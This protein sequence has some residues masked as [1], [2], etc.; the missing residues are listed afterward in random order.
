M[1]REA[2][3]ILYDL[4]EG[5][6]DDR[7][8]GGIRTKTIRAGK[9][10][11]V[12]CYPLVKL[13]ES[14]R[15]EYRRRTQR[16]CQA[17]LNRRNA[18]KRIRRLIDENFTPE[19]Y[20][21]T[22]TWDYGV[23]DRWR[24]SHEAALKK[25]DQARLPVDE[26]DARRALNN[27]FRRSKGLVRRRGC[28]PAEFKHLYVLESTREPRDE[29][30]RALPAHYHFHL[31]VHAPGLTADD[32]KELWPHGDVHADRLSLRDDGPARLAAYITKSH[33][34]E[35][36]DG[37]GRRLRRWGHS[38]NLREPTVTVSDRKISRRRAALV[39]RDVSAFGRQIFEAL[40]PGYV[41]AAEPVVRFSDFVAGAYIYARMRRRD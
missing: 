11:E 26:D 23:I 36:V 40:Y 37:S 5:E 12:E 9:A 17:A 33:G 24:M 1:K 2:Y 41:L 13:G 39:A 7:E 28:D 34:V 19:D 6:Y 3:E 20:V 32:L 16:P 31:V 15:E 18:E 30:P 22:L 4:P 25:W 21:L 38:K 8:V 14:A 27:W 35:R 10:I 29:D